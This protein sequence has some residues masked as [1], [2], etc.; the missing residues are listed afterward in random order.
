MNDRRQTA[1]GGRLRADGPRQAKNDRP[2]STI[3]APS[4]A[5]HGPSSMVHRPGTLLVGQSG[6]GT[7]VINA[8]LAG[9]I[10][11]AK[12]IEGVDRVLGMVHGVE[13]LL[14]GRVI[15]L[16]GLSAA[17][18]DH[19]AMTPSAALGS[20]RYRLEDGDLDRVLD[21]LRAWQVRYLCYIGG[22]DSARTTARIAAAAVAAGYP[23][24]AVAVP[25]TID[26]DLPCLDHTPGFGSAA[27]LLAAVTQDV[28]ADARAMRRVEP[29]RLIE[30][31]GRDSGWLTL[32]A[33]MARPDRS[34][35]E[36]PHLFY[37]PE[38]PLSVDQFLGD[39]EGVLARTGFCV[40]VVAETIRDA[41]GELL[42]ADR[43]GFVDAFGHRY[44]DG[45]APYLARAVERR[46]GTRARFDRP[47]TLLKTGAYLAST[48]DRAEAREVGRAAARLAAES[49]SGDHATRPRMITLE[50]LPGPKYRCRTGVVDLDQVIGRS[51]T[52]PDGWLAEDRR[53]IN[54]AFYQYLEPLL[55]EPLPAHFRLLD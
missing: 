2:R 43:A 22:D 54:P 15:D 48:V 7:P 20:C 28:A 16:G 5:V 18:L 33:A 50:R 38:R 30:T 4:P 51:K 27:R 40:A 41:Q 52:L 46:L 25:K 55:G 49:A 53:R 37:V 29:V 8:S 47:G 1:D 17:D 44:S 6:G 31:K 19:L 21:Q 12:A 39:V 45:P 23:L 32:A 10:E 14:A 35:D 13:G 9:I 34:P 3:R 36:P 42:G 11:T 24:T 26:N